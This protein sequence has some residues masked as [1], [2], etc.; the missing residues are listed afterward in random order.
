M[1]HHLLILFIAVPLLEIWLLFLIADVLG[2]GTTVAVV[3]FTGV[4]GASLARR[5]GL[6]VIQRFQSTVQAGGFPT[7][8][9]TDGALILSAGLLLL[10]PGVV[11]DLV[12]F[13]LLIPPVR[14]VLR[15]GIAAYVKRHFRVVTTGRGMSMGAEFRSR[16]TGSTG[17]E[18]D[19]IDVEARPVDDPP[20]R[21][22]NLEP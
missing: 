21:R 4:V 17:P 18:S 1:F 9:I 16:S 5:Q 20:R 10:T 7:R 8:E 14:A 19:V 3:L 13:G 12:G 15:R 11:T 2:W 6:R 22:E